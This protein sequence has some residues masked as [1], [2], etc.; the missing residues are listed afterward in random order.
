MTRAELQRLKIAAYEPHK[1]VG[2]RRFVE[3]EVDD[4]NAALEVI[5]RAAAKARAETKEGAS[6]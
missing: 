3:V 6:A 1:V 5:D 4:L 2:D